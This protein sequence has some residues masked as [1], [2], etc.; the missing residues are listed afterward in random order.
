MLDLANTKNQLQTRINA[1]NNASS[2]LAILNLAIAAK[3]AEAAGIYLTRTTLDTQIQRVNDAF[4][5]GTD[6]EYIIALAAG[7]GV[8]GADVPIGTI[9]KFAFAG[10]KFFDP[11]GQEWL[12]VGLLH[13]KSGYEK[14]LS[15]VNLRSFGRQVYTAQTATAGMTTQG[16]TDG[17]GNIVIAI[18]NANFV[19]VSNDNGETIRAVPHNHAAKVVSVVYVGGHFVLASNDANTL[20]TSYSSNGGAEFGATVNARGLSGAAAIDSVRGASDGTTAMFI[21]GNESAC[22][23]LTSGS[24]RTA[25]TLPA[26]MPAS[27]IPLID[28]MAGIFIIGR[29]NNN[30]YFRTADGGANFTTHPNPVGSVISMEIAVANGRF[31]WSGSSGSDYYFKN[32]VNGIDWV[33]VMPQLPEPFKSYFRSVFAGAYIRQFKVNG[34]LLVILKGIPYFTTDFVNFKQINFSRSAGELGGSVSHYYCFHNLVLGGFSLNESQGNSNTSV[35]KVD[36]TTPDYIGIH[37]EGVST[38]SDGQADYV[39]IK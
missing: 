12:M 19:L 5:A 32:S 23:A 11:I 2:E 27:Y 9:K 24:A 14:A 34:G 21:V 29:K 15:Q 28:V 38:I 39:R 1:L 7:V 18:S 6:I 22:L 37:S 13:S 20:K 17:L 8:D 3:K 31:Y 26:A 33:D 16:A 30:T 25:R 10:D 36:Y 4:G 35:L